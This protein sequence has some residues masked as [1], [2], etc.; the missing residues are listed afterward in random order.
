MEA[1][2]ARAGARAGKCGWEDG[3]V[4]NWFLSGLTSATGAGDAV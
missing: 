1:A 3:R 4:K 2:A